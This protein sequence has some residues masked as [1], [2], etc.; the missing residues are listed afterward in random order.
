MNIKSIFKKQSKKYNP[1]DPQQKKLK[2]LLYK[3]E[4]LGENRVNRFSLLGC[5]LAL[6]VC[7]S[8]IIFTGWNNNIFSNFLGFTILSLYHLILFLLLKNKIYKL[9]F[10]YVSVFFNVTCCTTILFGYS[11]SSGWAHALRT[12]TFLAY[13]FALVISGFYQRPIMPLF[14]SSLISLEYSIMFF[15]AYFFT[16][17]EKSKIETFNKAAI[18]LD[19]YFVYMIAFV[20][21]GMFLSLITTRLS[22]VLE[23][24]LYSEADAFAKEKARQ[25]IEE[26]SRQKTNFFIN[27]AHE[28]KTPITLISNYL[29][30]YISRSRYDE[31][32]GVIKSNVDKLQNDIVNFL[33]VEK[34][35]R[36]QV[37]YNHD[38]LIDLY[39]FLMD[40]IKIFK[41][42][43]RGKDIKINANLQKDV[44][45][46]IDP[47]ALDR[48]I[49]NLLD[50]AV[51]YNRQEGSIDIELSV[52]D[53][54]AVLKVKDTGIGI[55]KDQLKNIFNPYY[56]LSHEK[57][58]IQGMGMGLGIVKM[59]MSQVK[60]KIKIDSVEN[61]WT[62]A[63]VTMP[64]QVNIDKKEAEANYDIININKGINKKASY[65]LDDVYDHGRRFCILLVEDNLDMLSFLKDSLKDNYNV[66]LAKNG[67][68]ALDKVKSIPRQIDLIISDIMMDEMDGYAFYENYIRLDSIN[69][70]VPFIFLT[71]KSRHDEKLKGLKLGAVDYI[72]KPFDIKE[73]LAKIESHLGLNEA[74]NMYLFIKQDEILRHNMEYWFYRKYSITDREKVIIDYLLDGLLN[75]EIAG[76]LDLTEGT[77]KNYVMD[78]YKKIGVMNKIELFKEVIKMR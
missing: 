10:K 32:L 4:I 27:L 46:K 40:K 36:G 22:K 77:V 30:R 54:N 21:V 38:V 53:R 44:Y 18:G 74:K 70:A 43:A 29:D 69:R 1:S 20:F 13:F 48:V 9:F 63:V 55:P 67:K 52:I 76:K 75:K 19:I 23:R 68:E 62:L 34:L 41:E 64:A 31:D 35:E 6:I 15:Y 14:A 5:F 73:L 78:I 39:R 11:F 56:Q 42:T 61:E 37:F 28:T 57:R 3:E 33:D 17:V 25:A 59:I 16:G 26:A 72:Y 65:D 60:G 58:N 71:A 50:N 45:V 49:N 2:E 8:D 66:F 51:K 12:C 24:S 7:L 47:Y